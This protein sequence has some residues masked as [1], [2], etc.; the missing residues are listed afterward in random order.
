ME[1]VM[2]KPKSVNRRT[3]VPMECTRN[4]GI[5]RTSMPARRRPPSAFSFYTR[6]IHK[7]G[8]VDDGNTVTDWMEAGTRTR[9]YHHLRRVT[10]LWTQKKEEGLA[11]AFCRNRSSRQYHRHARARRFS[12]EV[13]RSMRV[14]GWRDRRVLR[15][16]RRAAPIRNRVAAGDQYK[17][18]A[19]PLATK[20]GP[21]GA[22]FEKRAAGHAEKLGAYAYPVSSRSRRGQSSKG[23]IDVVNQKAIVWGPAMLKRRPQIEVKRFPMR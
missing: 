1:A 20:D 16:R 4:I 23:V 5:A 2:N 14:F 8:D 17:V 3:A 13:E 9:H 7:I 10:C 22:N 6:L 15:R 19:S 18:R 12:A 11:K 21:H